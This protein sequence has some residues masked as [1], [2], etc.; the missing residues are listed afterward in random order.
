MN[1]DPEKEDRFLKTVL[2]DEAGPPGGAALKAEVMAAFRARH[3]LRRMARWASG[4]TAAIAIAGLFFW[5][6]HPLPPPKPPARNPSALAGPPS[7]PQFLTDAQLLASF[8]PGS[9]FLAEVDGHKELIF[10]DKDARRRYL[11]ATDNQSRPKQGP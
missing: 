8:P 10:V 11:A 5:L 7:H 1:L 3:A 4:V 6:G 2:S 9:C